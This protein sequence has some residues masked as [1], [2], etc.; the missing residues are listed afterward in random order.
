METGEGDPR[1]ATTHQ[2]AMTKFTQAQMRRLCVS[3]NIRL[4]A[5]HWKSA[6][7]HQQTPPMGQTCVEEEVE[8]DGEDGCS[9]SF[10]FSVPHPTTRGRSINTYAINI[11]KREMSN[12]WIYMKCVK[13]CTNR[14]QRF[15]K[16]GL[17][18][19]LITQKEEEA[20]GKMFTIIFKTSNWT[21]PDQVKQGH[22]RGINPD[23][24]PNLFFS[25]AAAAAAAKGFSGECR[26]IQVKDLEANLAA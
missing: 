25:Y 2:Q 11:S 23:Y 19:W 3:E 17:G 6:M 4:A 18:I 5:L 26:I 8:E 9:R 24:G 21:H 16:D 15:R 20:M 1:A 22:I 13:A 7:L 14:L 12:Y 10:V